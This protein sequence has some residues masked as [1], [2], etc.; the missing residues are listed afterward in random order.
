[1]NDLLSSFSLLAYLFLSGSI[2]IKQA[3]EGARQPVFVASR[4][5][6]EIEATIRLR[7]P[8][9]LE[10][11]G[12]SRCSNYASAYCQLLRGL[13]YYTTIIAAHLG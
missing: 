3:F 4:V 6:V 10:F 11:Q 8:A 2:L 5:T 12:H 7:I 13:Y 1:M 9:H